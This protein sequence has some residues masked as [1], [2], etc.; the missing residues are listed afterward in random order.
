MAID[1]RDAATLRQASALLER[2]R[3]TKQARERLLTNLQRAQAAL[4][5]ADAR[6]AQMEADVEVKL[7]SLTAGRTP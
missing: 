5:S 2:I 3:A 6:L 7:A 1:P 4:D